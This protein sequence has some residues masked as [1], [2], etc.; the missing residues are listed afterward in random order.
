MF[1]SRMTVSVPRPIAPPTFRWPS[2]FRGSITSGFFTYPLT[3]PR[4]SAVTT[5][6][7]SGPS[8][9]NWI[10]RRSFSP[11]SMYAIISAALI[12]R[13][14]AAVA[15]GVVPCAFLASSTSSLVVTANTRSCSFAATP[16]TM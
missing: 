16:R 12:V 3:P 7:C 9:S 13:P 6:P 10:V 2:S 5:M 15:T 4:L 8:P 11:F 14:R 1:R